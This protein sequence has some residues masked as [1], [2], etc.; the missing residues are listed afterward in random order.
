MLKIKN[1]NCALSFSPLHR[2][3]VC[4]TSPSQNQNRV[5]SPSPGQ[6]QN[7]ATREKPKSPF[8]FKMSQQSVFSHESISLNR[9]RYVCKC[10]LDAPLWQHGQ[11]RTQVGV[12]RDVYGMYKFLH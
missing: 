11:M 6:N 2:L 5:S 1:L 10:G 8:L 4:F 7:R 12:S 3:R 9:S